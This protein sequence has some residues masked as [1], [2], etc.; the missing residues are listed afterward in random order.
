VTEDLFG[1]SHIISDEALLKQMA[2]NMLT[3]K[4]DQLLDAGW[5]WAEIK[6]DLPHAAQFWPKAEIKKPIYEGDEKER[7]EARHC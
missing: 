2:R 6:S 3:A 5:G 4:C 1:D 7:L